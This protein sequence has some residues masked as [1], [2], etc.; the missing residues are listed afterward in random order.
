MKSDSEYMAQ[1][2]K[3]A[4]KGMFTCHPNPRVGC[5]IVVDGEVVGEGWHEKAGG[6]HAEIMALRNAKKQATGAVVYITMEPCCHKGK[7]GPCTEALIKAGVSKVIMAMQ[8]PNPEVAGKGVDDL[9]G[10]GIEVETGL[11]EADARALNPGFIMRMLKGRPYIRSKLAMS[12]DG[13][14]AMA[15]GESKWITGEEARR[16]V[17]F[18]R[19]RSSA[20]VTGIGTILSDDP[21]MTVRI[22]SL[23]E[24]KNF[25]QPLRVILDPRLSTPPHARIIKQPGDT[26]IVTTSEEPEVVTDLANAGAEILYQEAGSQDTIDLH[27]LMS[28]LAEE[29]VNEVL[30]ETGATLSGAMLQAGLIDEV[31]IY[32]APHLMGNKA[33]GLFNLT[34]IES[35][36]QRIALDIQDIRAIGKDWCITAKITY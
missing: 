13:R 2:L 21:S 22:N 25:T 18:L 7:T 4:E 8:D 33:R 35:M 29:E 30:L 3:L 1:A 24:N 32:M 27:K 11:L 31:I 5:V 17:Q 15:S 23:V 28:Y 12:L 19:A 34:G 14:T 10:A 26:L 9:R 6:P 36:D 16:D 20:I